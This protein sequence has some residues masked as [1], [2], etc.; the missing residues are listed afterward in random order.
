MAR[1]HRF[2]QIRPR[3]YRRFEDQVSYWLPAG[4]I[5]S[6]IL[7]LEEKCMTCLNSSLFDL[8]QLGLRVAIGGWEPR[9]W[10]PLPL[11]SPSHHRRYIDRVLWVWCGSLTGKFSVGWKI[12]RWLKSCKQQR[13]RR[14]SNSVSRH[15]QPS[16]EWTAFY[17]IRNPIPRHVHSG[18]RR[19]ITQNE[20]VTTRNSKVQRKG[21]C[22]RVHVGVDGARGQAVVD[23]QTA[24][25][26]HA[27]R[28]HAWSR[29]S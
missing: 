4:I 9:F 26:T 1:G 3:L 17:L 13:T 2:G 12:E 20:D 10:T 15:P 22:S 8:I 14:M 5:I 16:P 18:C 6:Y 25:Q 21:V 28:A 23:T 29:A 11:M 7:T 19:Q 27:S 24:R